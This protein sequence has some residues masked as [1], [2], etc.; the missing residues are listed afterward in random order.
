MTNK[1][2]KI[3]PK[4]N[5]YNRKLRIENKHK[6]HLIQYMGDFTQ[7]VEKTVFAYLEEV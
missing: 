5:F 7:N 2:F 1:I 3:Y 6:H 4:L